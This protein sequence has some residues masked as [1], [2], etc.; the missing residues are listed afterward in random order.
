MTWFETLVELLPFRIAG[1][2]DEESRLPQL[3]NQGQGILFPSLHVPRSAMVGGRED[4]DFLA[5]PRNLIAAVQSIHETRVKIRPELLLVHAVMIE[6]VKL[7]VNG[8]IHDRMLQK[9]S[10]PRRR[11]DLSGRVYE[12]IEN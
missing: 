9:S 3:S 6:I 10:S 12:E 2:F 8:G 1:K 5:N 4:G 11:L 7:G